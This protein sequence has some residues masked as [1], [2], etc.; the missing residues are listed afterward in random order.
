[1]LNGDS[2]IYRNDNPPSATAPCIT[3]SPTG[4]VLCTTNLGLHPQFTGV[5]NFHRLVVHGS[6]SPLE[7]LKL[8]ISE[9]DHEAHTTTNPN[10]FGPFSWTRINTGLVGAS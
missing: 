6:T 7:W 8:S 4:E 1:L 3:E 2:H 10:S 5:D 9:D